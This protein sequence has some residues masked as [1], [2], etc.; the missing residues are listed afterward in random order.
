MDYVGA[1]RCDGFR[2]GE[3]MQISAAYAGESNVT[4]MHIERP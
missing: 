2:N 3:N 1:G 4:S